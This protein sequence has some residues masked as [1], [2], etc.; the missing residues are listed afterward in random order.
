VDLPLLGLFHL[1]EVEPAQPYT[2]DDQSMPSSDSS[3]MKELEERPCRYPV[4]K[5]AFDSIA[6]HISLLDL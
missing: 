1:D 5:Q 6:R 4:D 3:R 2:S